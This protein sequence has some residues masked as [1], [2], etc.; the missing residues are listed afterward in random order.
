MVGT[1]LP[2]P[3]RYLVEEDG[4]RVGVVLEWDD[5]QDLRDALEADPDL[6][7]GL[8]EAE[9]QA[10][11]EGMLSSPFKERLDELL[12]RNREE[13]MSPR[14][15]RELDH[16]LEYIDSMNVLKARAM[17]TLQRRHEANE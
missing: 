8:N 4:R 1:H 6:L 12:E 17:Y 9:L 2:S 10:L 13:G 3:V 15:E 14:E 5:Y 11:A 7:L 16:L